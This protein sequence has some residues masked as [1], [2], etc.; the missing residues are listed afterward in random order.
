ML[1]T[2]AGVLLS[3][4]IAGLMLVQA[5][6]GLLM[7]GQYGDVVWIAAAWFGTD[8]VTLIVAVP[9]LIVGLVGAARGSVRGVLLWLGLFGYAAYNDAFYPLG[10]ALTTAIAVRLPA[11]VRREPAGPE[12]A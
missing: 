2:R 4:M 12:A 7:P 3:V 6:T 1:T 11:H 9:L 5:V 10:A 8:W